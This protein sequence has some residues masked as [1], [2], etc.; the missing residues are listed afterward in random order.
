LIAPMTLIV[1]S[2][3]LWSLSPTDTTALRDQAETA[4]REGRWAEALEAW[5]KFNQTA[6]ASASSRLAEAEVFLRL[7][8]AADAEEA[9]RKAT[10]ADPSQLDPWLTWLELLRLEGRSIDALQVGWT[11]YDSVTASARLGILRAL[12]L[13]LLADVPDAQALDAIGRFVSADPQDID[14]RL[15]LLDRRTST[16][17]RSAGLGNSLEERIK[18]VSDLLAQ[19][20]AHPG[21]RAA[22]VSALAD[23][24]A[25]EQA[26]TRLDSWPEPSRGDP[27]YLQLLA[28]FELEAGNSPAQAVDSLQKALDILPHDWKTRARLAQALRANGQEAEARAEAEK[29]ER[30]RETLDPTRLGPR[31][32]KALEFLHQPEARLD[33]AELCATI[34]L[35]QL[36]LAWRRE[37]AMATGEGG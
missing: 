28:R 27:R 1:G 36:A 29:V 37:A 13:A 35:D 21:A 15:A 8:R 31:L 5:R 33:L 9:L 23:A 6:D 11:A 32:T 7:D 3:V 20:P 22:L 2:L 12:T 25:W 34:G 18:I 30:L 4:A 24:G 26:Q 17:G 10:A 14:A 19:D 16:A